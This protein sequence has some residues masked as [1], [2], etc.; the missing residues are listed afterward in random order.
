[1]EREEGRGGREN[2]AGS[3]GVSEGASEGV[4]PFDRGGFKMGSE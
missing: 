4:M 1:M 3:E 2:E